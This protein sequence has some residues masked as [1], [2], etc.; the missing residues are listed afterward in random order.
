M[1]AFYMGS[2]PEEPQSSNSESATF[3]LEEAP[4]KRRSSSVAQPNQNDP[5]IKQATSNF[6]E[7]KNATWMASMVLKTYIEIKRTLYESLGTESDPSL[8][9]IEEAVENNPKNVHIED[10][11]HYMDFLQTFTEEDIPLKK[12]KDFVI[13]AVNYA[14]TKRVVSKKSSASSARRREERESVI[15]GVTDA[16]DEL[17]KTAKSVYDFKIP[18]GYDRRAIGNVK[19]IAEICEQ[20]E[21][22]VHDATKKRGG[23]RSYRSRPVGTRRAI[24]KRRSRI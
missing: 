5:A 14:H 12:L 10:L 9:T 20:N 4:K 23:A 18:K 13:K 16:A 3:H 22:L 24:T 2:L 17:L 7:Y 21:T 6:Q 15:G 11:L 8:E 19:R 1:S